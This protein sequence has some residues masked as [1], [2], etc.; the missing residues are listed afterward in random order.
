MFEYEI[1]QQRAVELR[2][3]ADEYRRAR[4]AARAARAE[5]AERAGRGS[6][7]H[8]AGGRVSTE[9]PGSTDSP[10][11]HRAPRTA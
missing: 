4:A 9:V 10:R 3:E 11:R 5:R 1:H 6:V 7:S 2:R 8:G